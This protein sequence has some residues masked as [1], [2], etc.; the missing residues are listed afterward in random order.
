MRRSRFLNQ[1]Q[2]S[3]RKIIKAVR[4]AALQEILAQPTKGR[5]PTLQVIIDLTTLEKRGKFKAFKQGV[6][7]YH[8]KRGLHEGCHVSSCRTM[9][10]SLELSYL[11][12]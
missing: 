3:T 1:Y 9:A 8:S 12:R 6:R 11:Q 2:W 4:S 7:V 10:N 5:R